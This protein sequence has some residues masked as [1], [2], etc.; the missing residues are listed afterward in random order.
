MRPGLIALL[1]ILSL[2]FSMPAMAQFIAFDP[3]PDQ[4]AP[5]TTAGGGT[6]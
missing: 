4:D 3:P 5:E 6:R 2:A 1:T